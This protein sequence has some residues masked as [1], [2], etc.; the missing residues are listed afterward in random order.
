[1]I[2]QSGL[3]ATAAYLVELG[4][5]LPTGAYQTVLGLW[6]AALGVLTRQITATGVQP[7]A[8][9]VDNVLA[10]YSLPANYFNFNKGG[11]NAGIR[12]RALGSFGSNGNNKE[13][14]IIFNPATAVV[15]STVGSG[16][17]TLCDTGTVTTNGGGWTLTGSVIKYGVDN[18]NTQLGFSEDINAAGVSKGSS[19]APAT[20]TATEN[21]TILIA[22]TG[23]AGTATTDITLNM[24]EILSFN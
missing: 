9:G 24:L 4:L 14:K 8:T 19:A 10:V 21:A 6:Q 13:V 5:R 17:T 7:G 16:G 12:I 20:I 22:V 23:N 15:G 18:S 11:G 3:F 1:M 2:S